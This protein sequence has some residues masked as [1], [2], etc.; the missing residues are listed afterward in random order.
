MKKI[1]EMYGNINKRMSEF[2]EFAFYFSK[3]IPK[4]TFNVIGL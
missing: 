3:K 2:G 1:P 4:I